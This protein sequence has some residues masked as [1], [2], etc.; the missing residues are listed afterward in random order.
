M[1][2]IWSPEWD[3]QLGVFRKKGQRLKYVGIGST[4]TPGTLRS[5]P[6]GFFNRH[7]KLN[8]RE[9]FLHYKGLDKIY[10][11]YANAL[12][13]AGLAPPN[14]PKMGDLCKIQDEKMDIKN[15]K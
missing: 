10:P 4:H 5:I 8:S 12:R 2:I 11:D 9:P 1:E 15:E 7:A 3:L 13:E 6:Q 14:F